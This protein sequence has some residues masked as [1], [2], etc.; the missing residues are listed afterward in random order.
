[1]VHRWY[2]SR[3]LSPRPL[4]TASTLQRRGSFLAQVGPPIGSPRVGQSA[5]SHPPWFRGGLG[6]G[7]R[8]HGPLPVS[9]PRQCTPR[10]RLR[11]PALW[12]PTCG[13]GRRDA[14]RGVAGRAHVPTCPYPKPGRLPISWHGAGGRRRLGRALARAGGWSQISRGERGKNPVNY[15]PRREIPSFCMRNCSVE[16][17]IPRRT[18]APWGR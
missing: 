6:A 14:G 2:S 5:L 13:C 17:F 15:V 3:S 10:A 11:R 4:I 9:T 18:A 8:R 12:R 16:R 1:M 7:D